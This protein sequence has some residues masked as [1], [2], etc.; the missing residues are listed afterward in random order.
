MFI[1]IS[2][3]A[4]TLELFDDTGC[5][6]QRSLV[7]TASNGPGELAGSFCTPRGQHRIRARIGAGAAMNTVFRGRRPTGELWSPE[8]DAASPGRDWILTR[9]LWLGGCEPGVNRFGEVDTQRRYVYI[10]GCPDTAVLGTPG[11]HG[12]VRLGNAELVEL[13]ERVTPQTPVLIADYRIV[14]GR[15]ATHVQGASAVR[16]RVFIQE[17]GIAAELEWDTWDVS[18]LHVLAL[19][20]QGKPIGTG[21]LLTEGEAGRIGRLAVLPEW[22]GKGVGQALL[23]RLLEA[24]QKHGLPRAFLHARQAAAG[25]Y[26][27]SGFVQQGGAYLETG[28]PHV[29]MHWQPERRPT[30]QTA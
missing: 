11:S 15:W 22:R 6:Q 28:S 13:F 24:G 9:I 17:Q 23:R 8:L 7:S 19:D 21:R 20:A 30:N 1:F 25:F 5:L 10:H 27:A 26:E 2:L 16:E 29:T 18:A 14:L 3:P 12:C 4:Q